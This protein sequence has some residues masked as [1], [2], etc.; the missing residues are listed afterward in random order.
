MSWTSCLLAN[1]ISSMIKLLNGDGVQATVCVRSA[2]ACFQCEGINSLCRPEALEHFSPFQF[3]AQYE[4]QK[5]L[6]IM[7][8]LSFHLQ[9]QNISHIIHTQV[10]LDSSVK[11]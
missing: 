8:R 1:E 4:L 3:Y 2:A 6:L 9:T 7:Q 11:V 5:Q 10:I